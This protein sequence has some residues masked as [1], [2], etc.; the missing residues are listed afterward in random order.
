MLQPLTHLGDKICLKTSA[1][2]VPLFP[3]FPRCF[4]AA[5]RSPW[6]GTG[7]LPSPKPSMARAGWE[8]TVPD[9]NPRPCRGPNNG[10]T[11]VQG[12]QERGWLISA[13]PS[14]AR[15]PIAGICPWDGLGLGLE[16]STYP[17]LGACRKDWG[18]VM[19]ESARG[20][21]RDTP[22]SPIRKHHVVQGWGFL[23]GRRP[24]QPRRGRG[25]A[26]GLVHPTGTPGTA[27]TGDILIQTPPSHD[28]HPGGLIFTLQTPL[29]L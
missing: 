16:P 8:R 11:G 7:L 13:L 2:S 3:F 5:R 22:R 28:S 15:S 27:R 17:D 1:L 4:L 29:T 21:R 6:A 12:R 14:S 19:E 10:T 23:G 24:P 25:L 20:G 26:W 18:H 9:G